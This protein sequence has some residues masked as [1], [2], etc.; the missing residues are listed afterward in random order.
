MGDPINPVSQVMLTYPQNSE[1]KIEAMYDML[2][3]RYVPEHLND[4][5]NKKYVDQKIKSSINN[6]VA[7]AGEAY[8]TL[9]ELRDKLNSNSNIA[10]G[11]INN[12][13]EQITAER[14]RAEGVEACLQ[15]SIDYLKTR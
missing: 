9:L 10:S 6:L 8:D 11:L 12:L 14:E 2:H 7:G 1:I 5:T 3:V 4:V 13:T 15:T